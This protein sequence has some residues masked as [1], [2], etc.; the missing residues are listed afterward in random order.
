MKT[1]NISVVCLNCHH[2]PHIIDLETNEDLCR[3]QFQIPKGIE[4]KEFLREM[5]CE[6]CGC[7][8]FMKK[9]N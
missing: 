1:Y 7:V 3:K 2:V 8:G 4:V 6:N 9:V 5:T